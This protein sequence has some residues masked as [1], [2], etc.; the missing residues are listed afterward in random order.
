MINPETPYLIYGLG[1]EEDER[2]IGK[3]PYS[4]DVLDLA[5]HFIKKYPKERWS[6]MHSMFLIGFN[7][8]RRSEN[9]S[10]VLN[11]IQE[12]ADRFKTNMNDRVIEMEQIEHSLDYALEHIETLKT[13]NREHI[14]I[15]SLI[16]VLLR[17]LS[18]CRE[19]SEDSVMLFEQ[20]LFNQKQKQ[21]PTSSANEVSHHIDILHK[22]SLTQ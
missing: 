9:N 21:E 22:E 3:E 10:T 20:Y 18:N 17:S 7:C 4:D 11:E 5:D 6:I 16:E 14:K 8:G 13:D 1:Y 15:A 2:L 12:E 19:V